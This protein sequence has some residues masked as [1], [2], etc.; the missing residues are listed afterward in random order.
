MSFLFKVSIK[1]NDRFLK[2]IFEKLISIQSS[3]IS[4]WLFTRFSFYTIL[5]LSTVA[6][7][8][9]GVALLNDGLALLQG[10]LGGLLILSLGYVLFFAVIFFIVLL[11]GS[12]RN[13][14]ALHMI[15]VWLL[16]CVI[17]P[18]A[19][20]QYASMKVPI[21]YMT[22]YLDVNRKQTYETYSLGTDELFSR[23]QKI[24]PTIGDTNYGPQ[25]ELDE[26]TVRRSISAIINHMNKGV[27][28]QIEQK[29]EKKNSIIRFSYWLNPISYVQNQWNSLTSSDY[30]S[31]QSYR[32]DVQV[33]IDKK[34]DILVF[35]TWNKKVVDKLTYEQYLE[36]LDTL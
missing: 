20:H 17:V 33:Y 1:S 15:G 36:E 7:I 13:S 6:L 26:T 23:L 21:N 4:K 5:M 30:Y 2:S 35:E 24:Y 25:P 14:M 8:I 32:R 22:D 10:E 29:N 31:Y 3:S 34:M 9:L 27:I 28:E 12:G 18:G 16:L 11:Y 19:V